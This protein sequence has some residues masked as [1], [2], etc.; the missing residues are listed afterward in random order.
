MRMIFIAKVNQIVKFF[1]KKM[2]KC[3]FSSFDH[4]Q[5]FAYPRNTAV[6]HGLPH[7]CNPS[8]MSQTCPLL[9]IFFVNVINDWSIMKCIT[10]YNLPFVDMNFVEQHLAPFSGHS[11]SWADFIREV[12]TS[13]FPLLL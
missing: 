5:H 13:S 11:A 4:L 7:Q 6:V 1:V 3:I 8:T 10:I 2:T 12:R 9:S